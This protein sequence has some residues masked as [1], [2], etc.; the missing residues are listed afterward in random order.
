[1]ASVALCEYLGIAPSYQDS[2]FTGG[3][4]FE[5]M[6]GHAAAAGVAKAESLIAA[7][8]MADQM[9]RARAAAR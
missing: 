7:I 8:T 6:V 4:V 2:S 9:A 5:T 1:M 3:S